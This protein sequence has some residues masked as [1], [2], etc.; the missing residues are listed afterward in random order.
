MP[1]PHHSDAENAGKKKMWE[2]NKIAGVKSAKKARK[3]LSRN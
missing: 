2:R 3:D 1:A